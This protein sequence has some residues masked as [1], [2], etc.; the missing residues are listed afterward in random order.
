MSTKKGNKSF[1][2]ALWWNRKTLF[3]RNKYTQRRLLFSSAG[4][5]GMI[6]GWCAAE[7][8]ESAFD[9]GGALRGIGVHGRHFA[10]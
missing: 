3:L 1:L 9:D 4:R 5:L 6:A 10:G 2:A 7:S 8:G